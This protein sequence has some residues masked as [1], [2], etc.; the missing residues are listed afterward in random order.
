MLEK[1]RKKKLLE[2]LRKSD[3]QENGEV[4]ATDPNQVLKK[5]AELDDEHEKKLAQAKKSMG[6]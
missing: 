1:L 2:S 5:D 3:S 4:A 6:K